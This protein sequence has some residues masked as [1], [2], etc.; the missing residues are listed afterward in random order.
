M[1]PNRLAKIIF[2]MRFAWIG[3]RNVNAR[4]STAYDRRCAKKREASLQATELLGHPIPAPPA[5]VGG[6]VEMAGEHA[7]V[8]ASVRVYGE[9]QQSANDDVR[10][11]DDAPLHNPKD[12]WPAGA[13]GEPNREAELEG[14]TLPKLAPT[15][16]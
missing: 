6:V 2:N 11:H 16:S 13:Y 10:G 9:W 7:I 12:S 3:S 5:S 4:Q 15:A 14:P 8:P 1:C